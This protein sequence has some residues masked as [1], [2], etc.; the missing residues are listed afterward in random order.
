M[1]GLVASGSARANLISNGNFETPAFGSGTYAYRNGTALTD[2]TVTSPFRGVV[3]FNSA[4]KPVD[5]GGI[6]SV[7]IESG[8]TGSSL[9]DTLSQSFATTPGASY[10]L[11]FDLSAYDAGGA[12]LGVSVGNLSTSLSGFDSGY[13]PHS[14]TFQALGAISALTFQ[15]SGPYGRSYP[16]LDNVSVVA[17]PD[18]GATVM[19]LGTGLL[20]IGLMRRKVA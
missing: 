15:N 14:Y 9:G 17:A 20:G 18:G 19:L 7:Q 8:V 5:A 16:H 12:L 4:Y 2:W 6:Y 11:N 3:Q 1:L 13:A 10:Q